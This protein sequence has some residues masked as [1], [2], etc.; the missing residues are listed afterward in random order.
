MKYASARVVCLIHDVMCAIGSAEGVRG[1]G[2][3]FAV[4]N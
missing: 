3:G 2:T 4:A 1:G